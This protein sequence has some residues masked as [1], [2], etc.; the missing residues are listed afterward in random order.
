MKNVLCF[1]LLFLLTQRFVSA[2]ENARFPATLSGQVH[3]DSGKA[4]DIWEV[5]LPGQKR[6]TT[7]DDA[8]AF[9]FEQVSP[10]DHLLIVRGAGPADTFSVKIHPGTTGLGTLQVHSY[11]LAGGAPVAAPP[12]IDIGESAF[13]EEEGTRDQNISGVLGSARDPLLSAAAFTFGSLRYQLRGY[14]RD[15]LEVYL[16]GLQV[17]DAESGTAFFGLWGGLNDVFRDQSVVFGLQANEDGFGGLSGATAIN[18]SAANQRRQSRFTYSLSNR[19]YRHRLMAT[20]S[21]GLLTSGWAFTISLGRRWAREGYIEGTSYDS[22]SYFL[23]VSRQLGRKSSLHVMAFGAPAQKGKAMPA[24][25]E[26]MDLAGSN[27]YNPNWGYQDGKKR[28]ARMNNTFQPVYLLQYEYNPDETTGLSLSVAY[29]SGYNGN[30]ALDWYNAR[31]PRPDYY[32]YLPSYY[33]NSSRGPDY[34][35]AAAVQARWLQDPQTGQVNWERLYETNRANTDYVNGVSGLRSLYVIGEDRDDTR[36]FSA[37][38]NFRKAV[39]EHMVLYSG[40]YGVSQRTESYRRMADLLGGDYYVNLNQFAERTYAG[41][42]AFNQVDLNHPDRIIRQGDR[43]SY[44]YIARFS[45][46]Y[47][48]LQSVFHYNRIDFFLAGRLSI[49]AFGR[50]GLYRNGLYPEDSYGKSTVQRF[51]TWQFKGGLTY[52]LDGRNYLFL[53]GLAQTSPPVFDNTFIAPR[54]RNLTVDNPLTEKIRSAEAGYLL[55]TPTYNGRFSVFATD[56]NDATRIMHFYYDGYATFVNYVMQHVDIRHLGGELALQTKLSPTVSA[57]AVMTWMQVFYNS[58]PEGSIYRDND[59]NSSIGKST[60]Y[61]KEY[62]AAAGPQSAYTLGGSY[63]SP[64]NWFANISFNFLDRNYVDINPSRLTEEAVDLLEPGSPQWKTVLGQERL[65]AIFTV[66]LFAG[67]S[68]LLSKKWKWLPRNTYLYVNTGI[69]NLL[70]NKNIRTGGFEQ[71]RYDFD[72]GNTE[73][74]PPKYFYGYGL[75]YFINIS[76]KF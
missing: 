27:F 74:F 49:D 60:L 62:N 41:N 48:W 72:N 6:M 61:L 26:A 32:G 1:S 8:G 75:N 36:K 11:G 28:N 56:I 25:Q 34:A 71:M 2:Q 55:R 5:L 66:D 67:K 73:R 70:N 33:I 24:T 43:Y 54:A 9:V 30:T 40:L 13:S 19:S 57:T 37:A 65:P 7:T 51:L 76:L 58:R 35:K 22:Y 18:A 69:N 64:K 45:K 47:A 16:N 39:G 17:N 46:A 12:L 52:K 21:T 63:R 44:S 31:D 53:N 4:G 14:G 38:L 3:A 29:Q 50:E 10:G 59:T 23:A 20:H 68:F 15:Q 42:G